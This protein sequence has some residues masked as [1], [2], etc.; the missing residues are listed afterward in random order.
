[1]IGRGMARGRRILL[2]QGPAGPFLAE[3]Q[4]GLNAAGHQ[5]LRALFDGGDRLF[6]GKGPTIRFNGQPEELRAWLGSVLQAHATDTVV[7]FGDERPIH[8]AARAEARSRGLDLLC[9]EEGYLRPGYITAEWHGTNHNSPLVGALG[10]RAS[11]AGANSTPGQGQVDPMLP[12]AR[13]PR[14]MGPIIC[15]AILQYGARILL[16]RKRERALF[17]RL[18]RPF[19]EVMRWGPANLLVK[20]VRARHDCR[21]LQRMQGELAG[22]YDLVA[23]QVPDDP[24]LTVGGAGWT[25]EELIKTVIASFSAAAPPDRHLVFKIHPMGRGHLADAA[26]VRYSARKHGIEGR[27]HC[28]YTGPF[29]PCLRDARG[30][31]TITS[32]SAISALLH[33]K[34]VVAL[35]RSI[36]GSNG[37]TLEEGD[38]PRTFPDRFWASEER[39]PTEAVA[40]FIDLIHAE[41]LVPGDFYH[42]AGRRI[43][44][45]HCL[46]KLALA[47][48]ARRSA[49]AM[50]TVRSTEGAETTAGKV[51]PDK[52]A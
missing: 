27:V 19:L 20:L 51:K 8:R 52:A 43:A 24:S 35:G 12:P 34:V 39:A 2:L 30:F 33:G 49:V 40:R 44:V 3:L 13:V 7:L 25:S 47:A 36:A 17:H 29:A 46:G 22:R 42:P 28:V 48:S 26:L 23:L 41:A 9:L 21:V 38:F 11:D 15:A 16:S 10:R 1:M 14:G 6:A 45:Q 31:V 18:Q 50:A 4:E 32:T 5:T 37:L